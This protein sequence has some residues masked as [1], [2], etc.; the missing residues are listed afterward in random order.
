MA[1]KAK[2]NAIPIE[3]IIAA[4]QVIGLLKKQPAKQCEGFIMLLRPSQV[5]NILKWRP[6]L[7]AMNESIDEYYDGLRD[8]GVQNLPV[9]D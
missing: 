4:S 1:R 8:A 9:L 5:K 3:D 7:E 6:Q 2:S